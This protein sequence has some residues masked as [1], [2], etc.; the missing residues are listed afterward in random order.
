MQSFLQFFGKF[1]LLVI[2]SFFVIIG[3][4]LIFRTFM[5]MGG[6]D[7]SF[8]FNGFGPLILAVIVGVAF[9]LVSMFYGPFSFITFK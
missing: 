5:R 3:V 1:P 9:F 7:P 4:N 8:E 2:G 6:K